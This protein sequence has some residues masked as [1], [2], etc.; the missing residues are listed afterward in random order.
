MKGKFSKKRR[1]LKKNQTKKFGGDPPTRDP[2]TMGYVHRFTGKSV[3][4][5]LGLKSRYDSQQRE[6]QS[7]PINLDAILANVTKC[8]LNTT[9]TPNCFKDIMDSISDLDEKSKNH[10]LAIAA[11]Y[12][13]NNNKFS[14]L[15]NLI[16][17]N[18]L[19]DITDTVDSSYNK[20]EDTVLTRLSF[21]GR[22]DLILMGFQKVPTTKLSKYINHRNINQNTAI[23]LT[24]RTEPKDFQGA[25]SIIDILIKLGAN[26]NDKNKA[27]ETALT[28]AI[29]NSNFYLVQFLIKKGIP[30]SLKD[31][32]ENTASDVRIYLNFCRQNPSSSEC[33]EQTWSQSNSSYGSQS[34]SSQSQ[35]RSKPMS[36]SYVPMSNDDLKNLSDFNKKAE[37]MDKRI[38][39]NN[40]RIIMGIQNDN[41]PEITKA[42]RK[43]A[44]IF[45]PDKVSPENKEKANAI[46]KKLNDLKGG[47]KSRKLRKGRKS[48]KY[49]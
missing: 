33:T 18:S 37:E 12:A 45:H 48:K 15:M 19:K 16:Q 30:I 25:K 35:P 9:S 10:V 39:T 31:L 47:R 14:I 49:L 40:K 5:R 17:D 44:F 13:A 3:R 8:V 6:S 46:M 20:G 34:N 42:Y 27:D 1:Y 36:S 2:K 43:L 38:A 28:L 4:E 41:P 24:G 7:S 22:S 29:R 32:N 23:I 11:L 26:L 21:K